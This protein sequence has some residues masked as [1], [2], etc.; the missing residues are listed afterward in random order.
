MNNKKS[1]HI[2]LFEAVPVIMGSSVN[3]HLKRILMNK[4]YV[5]F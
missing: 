1:G 5:M 2:H 3:L 4:L